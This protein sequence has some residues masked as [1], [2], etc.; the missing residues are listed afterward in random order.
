MTSSCS[1]WQQKSNQFAVRLSQPF[2]YS[3]GID[4]HRRADVR[5]TKQFLLHLDVCAGSYAGP[6]FAG[7][8][9]ETLREYAKLSEGDS[10][11]GLEHYCQQPGDPQR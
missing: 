8:R 5:M 2:W 4:V 7:E 11:N 10:Q 9:C 1:R 3:P 6:Q